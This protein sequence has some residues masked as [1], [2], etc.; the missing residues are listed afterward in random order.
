MACHQ[1][2]YDDGIKGNKNDRGTT[3]AAGKG[4]PLERR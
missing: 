4:L 1:E 2:K 3:V